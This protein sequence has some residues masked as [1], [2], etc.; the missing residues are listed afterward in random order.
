MLSLFLDESG[1]LGYQQ[2]S[3]QHFLIAVLSTENDKALRRRTKKI[4][5]DLIRRGW[6]KNLEIKGNSLWRQLRPGSE[7]QNR[8]ALDRKQI[9]GD[10]LSRIFLNDCKAHFSVVRKDKLSDHLRQA[11][12]GIVYNYLCG[13]LFRRAHPGYFRSALGASELEIVVDQR[14]KETHTKLKFDGYLDTIIRTECAYSG[15][16]KIIH[17]ESHQ[18]YGL[19]AVDLVSWAIYRKFE[20]NDPTFFEQIKPHFGY[21]DN[22]YATY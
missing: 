19:R 16:M 21:C 8:T 13:M 14:N 1:D 15:N 22:W 10:I 5:A 7:L 9:I 18:D 12:Y 11:E 17:R 2:G 20:H 3:S 6:P 4:S